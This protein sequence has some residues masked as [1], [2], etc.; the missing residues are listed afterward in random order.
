MNTTAIILAAGKGKR[1]QS[2][3][4]KQYLMI[5][6][7]PILAYTI[8]KFEKAP[9]INNIILVVGKDEVEY[10]KKEIKE[11][12]DFKKIK[13]IVSGGKERQDSVYE[14]IKKIDIETD[15]VL[16]H[17]G[18]RPLVDIFCIEKLVKEVVK[19]KACILGVKIKDTIKVVD[20]NG[21][22]QDTPNRDFLYAAQTPQGFY[23]EIIV[24]AYNKGIREKRIFT[25]DSMLVE[26][27]ENIQVKIVEGSY[28]NIK[29]TTKEDIEL[30][31]KYFEQS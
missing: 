19:N 13:Q 18:A 9:S 25:D 17:D 20:S 4:N 30:A 3:I 11:K 12:Y 31:K 15:I 8:D 27:Y 10:V 26:E 23:K 2:S 1:M 28:K 7:K 16:I 5:N 29:M 14:G 22:I 24:N 21:N 6:D